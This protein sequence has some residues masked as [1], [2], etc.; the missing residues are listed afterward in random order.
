ME[1]QNLTKHNVLDQNV[2][3]DTEEHSSSLLEY[4]NTEDEVNEEF[5]SDEIT[6]L[7]VPYDRKYEA[8]ALGAKWSPSRKQWYVEKDNLNADALIEEFSE[9]LIKKE[10]KPIIERTYLLVPYDARDF[11]KSL[12]AKF[13]GG[14]KKWYTLNNNKN[15]DQLISLYEYSLKKEQ[16]LIKKQKETLERKTQKILKKKQI[17]PTI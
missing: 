2:E 8:R 15:F 17:Q 4:V 12:G 9:P 5:Y 10:R 6:F 11:A 7:H 14:S 1:M 3:S 13:D 16:D